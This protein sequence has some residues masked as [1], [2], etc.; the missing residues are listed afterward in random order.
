MAD[1]ARLTAERLLGLLDDPETAR[2]WLG[3]L[4]VRDPER[5]FRDLRD[6]AGRGRS[7][8][9]VAGLANQLD[10][11]L[12]RCPDPGMALTNLE[13]FVAACPEPEAT[14]A[15]LVLDPRTT[16]I[17]V[18]LF[19]TSQFFSDLLIR[20]PAWLEWL[21]AG[22]ERRDRSTLIDDLWG[23]LQAAPHDEAQ[24]IALRRF[25]RRESLRI[26]YNDIVRDRPLEVTTLD[27][28][29]LADA[30]V[31][32]AY[33]LA[34]AH[35]EARHGTPNGPDGGPSRF[36]VLGLGKLG[37]EEL[38][39]SSDI[40]LIFLYDAEGQTNG[41][42]VV[43]NAEF[44]AR[45]G[46]EVVRLLADHTAMGQAY[47]V[48]MRLRPEGDQGPLARSL[49]ATLGYYETTGRT[50][51]RQALIK[52]RPVAGDLG[53]GAAF[54]AAI[55]PFV[56]RRYLSGAEIGEIKA[57]KRRIEQRALSAGT[58]GLEV[59]TGRGGLRDVE[60]VVQFLQLL[61]GGE[62]P[63]VRHANTLIAL[64]RL[65]A[66]GCLDAEERGIMEDTYRFLRRVEHRLQTMF[67]RQ[68]HQMPADFEEQRTLAIRLGYPPAGPWEDRTGP[69]QR[70]LSDYRAKTELNRKILDHLLHDA[71]RDDAG[72]PADP[73]VDLVLD[74]EP[75]PELIAAA[76]APFPFQDRPKAYRNLM[77]L[78]REEIPFLSQ[79]RC[80]HFLAAIAPRLLQALGRAPDPDMALTNL[81]K[82]SASLGAKAILWELFSFNPPTL[83][84]FVE[85]CATSQFLSEI[86]I[87]NPG[88]IDDLRDSLVVD[89][90]QPA[91]AIRGE[92]GELCRGAEDLSP[93]LLSFRNKEWVR[94]GTRDILGREPIR[95]ATRELADV[96]EAIVGQ[97]ARDQERRRMAVCG[98]PRRACDGLRARWAVLGLGKLGGRELNYGSDL[99]LVFVCESDGQTT[100]AG[101][102]IPNEQFF[103]EVARRVLKSLGGGCG[104]GPLYAI[105]TRLRPHGAS[106]TLVSTLEGFAAYYQG[107]AQP[108]ERLMLARARVVYAAHDFGRTVT[109]AIRAI[110][111]LPVDPP[112]LARE[113][114]A[115]RRKLE[116]SRGPADL[117]RG[118]GG[119]VDIEFLTQY[120]Q[121]VHGRE[122]P[123]ILRPNLWDAL[124]A[125]R[126]AGLIDAEAHAELRDA[127]DFSRTVES[128]L[129]IV[130]NRTGSELPDSLEDLARLALRLNY[131]DP[132]PAAVAAF[133]ADAARHASRTRALFQ[134]IVG[135]AAEGGS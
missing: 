6:L 82:V 27:L 119:S 47:R 1:S 89:R 43:S 55:S 127:Y 16:E 73:V 134:Q 19:S 62:Y 50:W 86:L 48:D 114:L 130:H 2:R 132:G 9:L 70:F 85:V 75:G 121:L 38:N 56:Y 129:R 113:V 54:L 67:D 23:E 49:A 59:K 112:A 104:S 83:R 99:D 124:D 21:R 39:Y 25:R 133:R 81:E 51:E 109:E 101:G 61:H 66:V 135:G 111:T 37:G 92:L 53:L 45:M 122:V 95:N 57:M 91:S 12:P 102:P 33:R 41:P 71:F 74:P 118:F 31:E 28:S 72:A 32:A 26:G 64:S 116:D 58:A 125:L 80:R 115:M 17:V 76:L 11:M 46:G 108:W 44:F 88:M 18:Q 110:L 40:D 22:A 65:E 103:G 128:R 106:G 93:I 34:Y 10:A 77:A 20:D 7:V 68:T 63:E 29:H 36:V 96:A 94:I 100:G 105:D 4:G 60:F 52:C 24:R 98:V 97:V 120:L 35:A 13:R 126:R 5:G 78:A 79:A 107:P 15:V 69:A 90:A 42:R 8:A 14:L 30:C 131:D 87:T 3:G 84:L 117:K 123:D